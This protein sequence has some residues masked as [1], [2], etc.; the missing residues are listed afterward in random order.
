MS[1]I[2]QSRVR[3]G[4]S[5]STWH[6]PIQIPDRRSARLRFST[7]HPPDTAPRPSVD[8]QPLWGLSARVPVHLNTSPTSAGPA[9]LGVTPSGAGSEV[10]RRRVWGLSERLEQVGQGV[11]DREDRLRVELDVLRILQSAHSH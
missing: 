2:P 1:K 11:V 7:M 3:L 4:E 5:P 9:W 8:A 10:R 6:V